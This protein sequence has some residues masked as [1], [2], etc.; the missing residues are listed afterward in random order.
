LWAP[1]TLE[2]RFGPI[3]LAY[4]PWRFTFDRSNGDLW[5]GDECQNSFEEVDL[6]VKGGNYGWKAVIASPHGPNATHLAH[7]PR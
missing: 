1:R 4:N 6:V 2:A 5:T 7:Y 3:G